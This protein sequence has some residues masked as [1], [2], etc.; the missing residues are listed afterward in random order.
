MTDMRNIVILTGAGISAESGIDTF[1]DGGGLWE[2]HRVEDVATPEAFVRDPD[3]VLRFYDQR[4]EA[5]Q[6]KQP[7]A[8]HEALAKLKKCTSESGTLV[9]HASCGAS[10][11]LSPAYTRK[12]LVLP[13][14]SRSAV[15]VWPLRAS[16]ASPV[17]L[18]LTSAHW[19]RS[20]PSY[21]FHVSVCSVFTRY[22]APVPY[23]PPNT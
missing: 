2:Q 18:A 23:S 3:L 8:A 15:I 10:G 19:P 22:T 11:Q 5:I 4:R 12:P 16:G 6:A 21:A 20:E 13:A 1:R 9:L 7:N 17:V 14:S